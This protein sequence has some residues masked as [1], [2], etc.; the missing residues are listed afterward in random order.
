MASLVPCPHCG[1]RPKEEFT[2]KGA[3]LRRPA[4]GAG[5]AWMDYVYLRENPR[6]AYREFW[7]HTSGCR[8]W[9]IVERDTFSHEIASVRDAADS[10][11][12]AGA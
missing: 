8:R 3:A 6:G 10:G 11:I 4:P 5:E 2:I 9:L 1:A 7:H 12:G